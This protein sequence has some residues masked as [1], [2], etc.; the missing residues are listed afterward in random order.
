MTPHPLALAAL[1]PLLLAA[2][3]PPKKG[4]PALTQQT[5]RSG[6]VRPAEQTALSFDSADLAFELLPD[7]YRLNGVAT[8]GFTARRP[9]NRLVLD[10]DRNLPVAAVAIDGVALD[11]AAW[12]NPE[13]QLV[14]RLPRPLAAGQKVSARIAYGGVPHVA[15]NAPWGDG[16]VWSKTPDGRLWFATTA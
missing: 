3:G 14:I 13:G 6:G 8:L 12:S 16:V 4:E 15:V 11:K 9:V 2:A 7:R 1:L 10:L 5:M